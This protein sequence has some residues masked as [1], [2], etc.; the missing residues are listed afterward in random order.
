MLLSGKLNYFEIVLAFQS[1]NLDFY[2]TEEDEGYGGRT[3][4][5]QQEC[6]CPVS[7]QLL[8]RHESPTVV[9]VHIHCVTARHV[10]CAFKNTAAELLF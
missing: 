7:H 8:W 10:F 5:K 2:Q 4:N 6:W 1:L 9:I 3:W